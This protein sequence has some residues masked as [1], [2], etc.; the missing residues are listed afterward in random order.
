M[1]ALLVLV[2]VGTSL[3][4]AAD[5]S[6]RDWSAIRGPFGLPMGWGVILV[7]CLLVWIVAFPFYLVDRHDAPLKAG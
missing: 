1:I 7:A 2:V 6:R 4:A 5:A 3:W